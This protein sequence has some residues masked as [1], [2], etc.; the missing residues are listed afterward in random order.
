MSLRAFLGRELRW[1][2]RRFAAL[3]VV[4]IGLP[5]VLAAASLLFQTVIPRT[6]PV[7]VVP[8]SA[9]VTAE[10]LD[11]AH[12]TVRVI[13]EPVAYDTRE[14]AFR[15]LDREQ[16]YGV[17]VVPPGLTAE[18][19]SV[20]V[21]YYISGQVVPYREPSSAVASVMDR[22]LD[23]G[24]PA[25]VTVTRRVVGPEPTLSEYLLPTFLF[26]L[27]GVL[28]FAYLPYVLAS[29]AGALDRVRVESSLA[30]YLGAK[31]TAFTALALVPVGTFALVARLLAYEVAVLAP[32]GVAV[33]LATFLALAALSGAVTF[34]TRFSTAGRLL[35]VLVLFLVLAFSGIVYPA[36]FF[37]PARRELIRLVPT[38]YAVVLVRNAML[39][40]LPPTTYP[41]AV[42]AVAGFCLASLLLAA[43]SLRYYRRVA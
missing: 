40:G 26:V 24:L 28:A 43:G 30:A 21:D 42:A 31:L 13:A 2:R 22:L 5:A 33:L 41:V 23:R 6:A 27:L 16:V 35:N 19:G 29:E 10:E 20:T 14:A 11:L 8:G 1:T 38:H 37:S 39:K 3:L 32:G 36:G 18:S 25:D 12:K 4:L 9:S 17:V 7:A 15:A 34:L